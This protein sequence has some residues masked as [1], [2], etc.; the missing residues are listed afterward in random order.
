MKSSNGYY[1][2]VMVSNR[3]VA[4]VMDYCE[5]QRAGSRFSRLRSEGC[6]LKT[7]SSHV[8]VSMP[9][10]LQQRMAFSIPLLSFRG[11]YTF[12]GDYKTGTLTTTESLADGPAGGMSSPG[13]FDYMRAAPISFPIVSIAFI[14]L[15]AVLSPG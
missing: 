11:G 10:A 1:A 9:A 6:R 4:I 8:R 3:Y 12:R 13:V 5:L 15:R 2:Q 14:I 7:S